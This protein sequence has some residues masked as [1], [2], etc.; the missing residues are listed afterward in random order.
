MKKIV[1]LLSLVILPAL[2]VFI[3]T[4]C[5]PCEDIRPYYNITGIDV[6]AI[7]K[8]G[9]RIESWPKRDTLRLKVENQVVFTA[10]NLH[11]SLFP[12]L[13]VA[14][15][16]CEPDGNDGIKYSIKEIAVYSANHYFQAGAKKENLTHIALF[17]PGMRYG[18][19]PD[20]VYTASEFII[21]LQK[22]NGY[23]IQQGMKIFITQPSPLS[24]H[25]QF[26]IEIRQSDGTIHKAQS[27]PIVWH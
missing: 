17:S 9:D 24:V 18:Y 20:K 2:Q 19:N 4:S 26:I 5:Q 13:S 12:M 3:F 22:D 14:K 16:A 27:P 6:Y 7:N 11:P 8:A 25:H 15:A 23:S 10:V 21:L 1:S